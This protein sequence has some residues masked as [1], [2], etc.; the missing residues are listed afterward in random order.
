MCPRFEKVQGWPKGDRQT[1]KEKNGF[2][3]QANFSTEAKEKYSWT[4]KGG[5][6]NVDVIVQTV[7]LDKN[8]DECIRIVNENAE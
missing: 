1:G 7:Q 8:D 4:S 6:T 5:R 3:M 2:K